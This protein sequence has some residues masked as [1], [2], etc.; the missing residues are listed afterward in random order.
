VEATM[1]V[2]WSILLLMVNVVLASGACGASA[3]HARQREAG[4][5]A[6]LGAFSA[7]FKPGMT[8]KDVEDQLRKSGRDFHRMCCMGD[9]KNAF[10]DLT[11][12]GEESHPWYCSA[13]SVYIGFEF[14]SGGKHEFAEAHDSDTLKGVQ[15]FHWFEGCL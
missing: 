7:V 12:I 13:H 4:Y 9:H 2:S 1:R 3:Q 8:R 10:D 14:V 11:K 5:Q 15:I 6:Q